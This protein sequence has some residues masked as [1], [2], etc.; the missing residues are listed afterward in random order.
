MIFIIFSTF[1]DLGYFQLYHEE[2]ANYLVA[3]GILIIFDD[4]L[5]FS[6]FGDFGVFGFIMQ[7][8]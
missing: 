5:V 4:F 8:L 7:I 1:P 6:T 2:F 3:F